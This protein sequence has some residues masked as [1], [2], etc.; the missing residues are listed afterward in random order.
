MRNDLADIERITSGVRALREEIESIGVLLGIFMTKLAKTILPE[1]RSDIVIQFRWVGHSL[2]FS[3]FIVPIDEAGQP[4]QA[5]EISIARGELAQRIIDF[6]RSFS[7]WRV[8]DEV[9]REEIGPLVVP[10]FYEIFVELGW[11]CGY[12][13]EQ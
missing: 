3:L 7:D 11:S 6:R 4:K 5:E 2:I 10:F 8:S 1:R 9:I 13:S 12:S